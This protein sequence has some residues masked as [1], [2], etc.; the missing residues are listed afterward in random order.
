VRS[1]RTLLARHATVGSIA[2][3]AAVASCNKDLTSVPVHDPGPA[4]TVS[5]GFCT[6]LEPR[7]VAFQDG[8]GLWVQAQPIV[9]G[10]QTIFRHTFAFDHA[11]I[12]TARAFATGLTAL[13]IQYGAPDE[14]T[15]AAD[16]NPLHCGPAIS[17]TILG[18]I[19]GLDTNEVATISASQFSR[20]FLVA[21]EQHSFVLSGLADGPQDILA[22]RNT[23]VNNAEVLT[24]L[25]LR[26]TPQL[27]DSATI[28]VLDFNATEAFAPAVGNVT[29]LG[30]PSQGVITHTTLIT[31]N[32]QSVISFRST[33]ATAATHGYDAVPEDKLAAS[34]LQVLTAA[35]A[36]AAGMT[37][38]VRTASLYFRAPGNQTLTIGAPLI[39][40]TVSTIATTP[41]LRLRAMFVAQPDY[42][43]NT[44]ITYQ[45]GDHTLVTVGMTATYASVTGRGYDLTV[46]NLSA[47]QGF[48]STWALRAGA[49]L[50]WNASRSGGTRGLG[51]NAMPTNGATERNAV[52]L[53]TQMTP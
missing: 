7:W 43:A 9:S 18:T 14:L 28:P 15:I 24:R 31:A 17:K 45:Q 23:R 37:D 6:G 53:F 29:V 32:S 38:A 36:P 11:A 41:T 3:L 47:V 39:P 8:D 44:L 12:A 48:E 20:A 30:Q 1:L 4:R 42:D 10:Q 40:P 34:D 33:N 52:S 49:D 25:I 21:D 19:A 26:R 5:V 35:V 13:D 16:T 51:L 46:P 22:A 50:M 27:A 2:A